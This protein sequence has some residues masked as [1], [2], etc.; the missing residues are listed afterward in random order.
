MAAYVIIGCSAAGLAAAETIRRLQPDR[1]IVVVS[2][3]EKLYSRCMLHKLLS[4]ERTLDSLEFESQNFFEKNNIKWIGGAEVVQVD[5]EHRVLVLEDESELPYEKLLI[6][7]GSEYFMPPIPNFRDGKNVF[8]FRNVRDVEQITKATDRFGKRVIIVGGGI[9][10]LDVAYGL[11]RRGALVTLLEKE[12]RLMPLQTDDYV[13]DLYAKAFRD[14]GCEIITGVAVRN[15]SINLEDCIE[16]VALDDGREIPCD[17]VVVATSVK[18]RMEFLA[19]SPIQALHMNYHI[20]TVLS[21]YLRKTGIQVNK[22]LE[23][24]NYMETNVPGIYGAGDVTGLSGIWPDARAMGQIAA[25]N[26]C[27]VPDVR[28]QR[29]LEKNSVN[30]YGITM[31]SL[32][33]VNADPQVYDITVNRQKDGYTR[34]VVRDGYLEG[35]LMVGDLRNA[36]VYQHII[37]QHKSIEGMEKRLFKLSFADWYDI[38]EKT[39]EFLYR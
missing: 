10:G 32:G 18:P 13:S 21:H 26:M 4:G 34:L 12:K 28:P 7:S 22:G 35:A 2:E 14:A 8:G 11:A 24:D 3:D 29:F 38:D 6:A 1:E 31:V 30:F 39:G 37:Q 20:Q 16:S 23:I 36:G 19:G 9:L 27:G 17:F 5:E 25:R 33:K 15:S